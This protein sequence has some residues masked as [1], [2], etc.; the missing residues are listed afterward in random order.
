MELEKENYRIESRLEIKTFIDKMH[1]AL[2]HGASIQY[3]EKR[4][5]DESRDI[6]FTNKYTMSVL[7]PNED[8]VKV[9]KNELKKIKVEHYLRTV[10]DLRFPQRS[11]MREF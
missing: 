9:L 8:P 2:D 1:Y 6:R 7:F 3:I 10:K 5:V 11:E 4:Q